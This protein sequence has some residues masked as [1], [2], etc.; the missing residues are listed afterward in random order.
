ME[1]LEGKN[2]KEIIEQEAPLDPGR[3]I[4]ISK[5]VCAALQFAHKHNI[6]HRDIKPHNIIITSEGEVKVTDF[7]IARADTSNL[8]Q[9][10]SIVGTAYYISPEQAQGKPAQTTSDIYSLGIVMYELLTGQVP[11]KGENPV[12]IAFKQ[13]HETPVSPRRYNPAIPLKLEKIL[14]K[15][16]AKNSSER[17]QSAYQMKTDLGLLENRDVSAHFEKNKEDYWGD[18]TIVMTRKQKKKRE[19]N[20]LIA[21]L[22]GLGVLILFS[23]AYIVFNL[24]F[25]SVVVPSLRGKTLVEA[26]DRLKPEGLSLKITKKTYS[27][28]FELGRIINQEPRVGQRISS[29]GIVKVVLSKGGRQIIVPDVVGKTAE[30]AGFVLG[31]SGLQIG[32]T[33]RIFSDT[34]SEDV[35]IGQK[36][37]AYSKVL[38]DNT[39]S[40]VV[41]RGE[42]KIEVPDVIGRTSVEAGSIIGQAGLKVETVEEYSDTIVKDKVIKQSP[43]GGSEIKKNSV[44]EITVSKGAETTVVPYL[45]GMDEKEAKSILEKSGLVVDVK[46]VSVNGGESGKVLEQYPEANTEVKKGSIISI[47]VKK[48]TT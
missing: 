12:A 15:A 31:Q 4:E 43:E 18:K 17:Y 37:K 2:L 25:S 39:V 48:E 44:V 21:V 19:N 32:K 8:T 24:F 9:T 47:S 7:G 23:G 26:R 34:V 29:D 28:V 38:P 41:S 13:V 1:Y 11:F 22:F 20:F 27:S 30:D 33:E 46:Y 42:E 6:I 36:P 45:V 14:T 35:V 10:G 16:L 3:V 40:I 5:K